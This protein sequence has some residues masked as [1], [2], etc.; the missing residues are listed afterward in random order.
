MSTSKITKT[1]STLIPLAKELRKWAE[2]E[3]SVNRIRAG[4][5]RRTKSSARTFKLKYLTGCIRVT[6]KSK[7]SMQEIELYISDT[8]AFIESL[9]RYAEKN[10]IRVTA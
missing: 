3:D 10:D 5:I 7:A 2:K 8:K 9:Q 1:H 6:V 4:L